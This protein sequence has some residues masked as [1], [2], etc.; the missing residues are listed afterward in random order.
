MT[1]TLR[2]S[3]A[4]QLLNRALASERIGPEALA[5]R[6]QI[7]SAQLAQFCN[8]DVRMPVEVRLALAE[9]VGKLLPGEGRAKYRLQAVAEAERAF[10]RSTNV[11]HTSPPPSRFGPVRNS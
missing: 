9:V 2:R 5:Q 6:L 10:M 1:Q 7:T 8:G 4:V 3:P 11:T